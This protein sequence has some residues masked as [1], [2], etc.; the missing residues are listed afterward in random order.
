M[1]KKTTIGVLLL[2]ILIIVNAV[3]LGTALFI[4]QEIKQPKIDV[5]LNLTQITKDA[6]RFTTTVLTANENRFDLVVTNLQVI[7]QT[8]DGTTILD[9]RFEGGTIPANQQRTFT[10]NDT[11]N[12]SGKHTSKIYCSVQGNVG[13]KFAGI[14]EKTIPIAIDVTAS[15]QDLLKNIS[16]PTLR[17]LAMVSDIT[18]TGV[19]F[20]G[21]I[22]V[23]NPNLFTMSL[24]NMTARIINENGTSVG[25]FSRLQGVI[26][27]H[28]TT[29]FHLNGTLHYTALDAKVL[30]LSLTGH[31]GVHLMGINK[32]IELATTAQLPVPRIKE[33]I[34]HNESLGITISIEAKL[35]L[36][37]LLTTIGLNLSNPSKIPLQAHDMLCSVY[38]VTGG[39]E[40]MIAQKQMAPVTLEPAQRNSVNTQ[41]LIPYIKFF[42]AGTKT[43]FPN[44]FVIRIQGNFTL[45]GVSQSIPVSIFGEVNPHFIR[46]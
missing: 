2:V 7:G 29:E 46:S 13:V 6:L 28:G 1:G 30:T 44:I 35:R 8:P 42:T 19:V 37:G 4:L 27:P 32:S 21:T 24:E 39:N 25:E 11:L 43:L 41:I 16:S 9:I 12:F 38:G 20:D 23:D 5:E 31:A 34:F 40:K 45:A 14:F 18:D 26:I 3:I 22:F 36:R 17:I 10:S 15:F 33:L